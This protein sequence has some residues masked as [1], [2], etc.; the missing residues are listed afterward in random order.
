MSTR[1]AIRA[2]REVRGDRAVEPGRVGA[3][4]V[5]A[6]AVRPPVPASALDLLRRS[7]AELVAAQLATSPE[8][9]F[10][11]AHLAAL[12]AGA[13]LLEV[14]GR[15]RRRPAPRTVWEMVAAVA[16]TLE[17]W[18]SYFAAG[19]AARAAIE[20]GRDAGMDDARADRTVA[21]AED[22]QDAVRGHLAVDAPEQGRLLLHAS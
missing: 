15:P 13:A 2:V 10:V 9:R 12:R 1:A 19:A 17:H 4:R 16:P 20:V 11:H 21:A 7:D 22:F 5:E 14:T 18:T 3:G 6:E 8:E